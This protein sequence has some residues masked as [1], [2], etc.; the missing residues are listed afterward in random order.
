MCFAGHYMYTEATDFNP[1]DTAT[2]N[3]PTLTNP[4]Q[5]SA[6][7]LSFWWNMYGEHIGTMNVT[8]TSAAGVKTLWSLSGDQGCKIYIYR[9]IDYLYI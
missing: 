3:L 6:M 4:S 7:C 9:P 1:G 5:A 8:Q 2:L